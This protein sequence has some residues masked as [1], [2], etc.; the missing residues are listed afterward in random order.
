MRPEI[1]SRYIIGP[2]RLYFNKRLRKLITGLMAFLMLAATIL[3]AKQVSAYTYSEPESVE[4]EEK[5]EER[6]E[7][8]TTTDSDFDSSK[9]E[10]IAEAKDLRTADTKTFLKADGTYVAVLYGDVVHYLDNGKYEDIDL[11]LPYSGDSLSYSTK[12]N[13]F[14]VEF[15]ELIEKDKTVKLTQGDY[16]VAWSLNTSDRASIAYSENIEKSSDPKILTKTSQSVQ[17]ERIMDGV[18]IE[19]IVTGSS[20]KENIIL[21]KYIKDF[22]LSFTYSL[23]NLSLVSKEDGSYVFVNGDK[24]EVFKFDSLYMYDAKDEESFDVVLRVEEGKEGNYTV[25]VIPDPEWLKTAVYPVTID[26]TISSIYQSFSIQDT[27][28]NKLYPTSQS[29][30]NNNSFYVANGSWTGS[31]RRGLLSFVMPDMSGK[32]ITYAHLTLYKWNT[33]TTERTIA[34][35][36]NTSS[37]TASSVTWNSW[38]T[39]EPRHRSEMVDYVIVNQGKDTPYTFNITKS[40]REWVEGVSPNYGFTIKDKAN[41]G[42]YTAFYSSESAKKPVIE[43]GYIDAEGLKSFW[44]YQTFDAGEAG[45]VYVADYTGLM[46]L[47]RQD[48]SF[49]TERDSL[50]LTMVY[51]IVN[52]NTDIGYGSGWRTNYSMEVIYDANLLRYYTIDATGSK[53]YYQPTEYIDDEN[54]DILYDM[55][56]YGMSSNYYISEDGSN[57]FMFVLIDE[58]SEVCGIYIMHDN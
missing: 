54:L 19:Y 33:Q 9:V 11:T 51:N 20:V 26:P 52:R 29:Y 49:S 47:V 18:A 3:P 40:V 28:I 7:Y 12:A 57:Q 13:S 31:E 2:A 35:H 43:I 45:A 1:N 34:I 30:Y 42:A 41:V 55:E 38:M 36:H 48:L 23:A 27:Y 4:V 39:P 5:E 15:P 46:T 10:I 37:F 17:Y 53:V 24:E 16:E 21:D 32:V 14:K 8:R 58:W 44:T 6:V 56:D 22:S 50:G 25:T